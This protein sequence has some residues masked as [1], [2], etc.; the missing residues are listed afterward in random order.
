MCVCKRE[1]ERGKEDWLV[2]DKSRVKKEAKITIV[3]MLFMKINK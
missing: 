1:T 3:K 2:S